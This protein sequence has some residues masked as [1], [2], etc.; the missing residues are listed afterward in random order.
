MQLWP[1]ICSWHIL[2]WAAACVC[3][4]LSA[5]LLPALLQPVLCLTWVPGAGLHSPKGHSL[6]KN[7]NQGLHSHDKCSWQKTERV[8]PCKWQMALGETASIPLT[9]CLYPMYHSLTSALW[10]WHQ[11]SGLEKTQLKM[12]GFPL[13]LALLTISRAENWG[14]LSSINELGA[15]MI[16]S[17]LMNTKTY[18]RVEILFCS[19]TLSHFFIALFHVFPIPDWL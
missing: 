12:G 4:L 7:P 6:Q 5:K 14:T 11:H 2:I 8:V 1:L 9:F 3:A 18:Q 16:V 15:L 17:S 10:Q 19:V 13:L